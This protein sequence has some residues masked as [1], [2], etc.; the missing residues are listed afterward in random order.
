MKLEWHKPVVDRAGS[1]ARGDELS[2][3]RAGA[4]LSA[5]RRKSDA[6]CGGRRLGR[7]CH[8]ARVLGRV[9]RWPAMIIKVLGSA[10]GGGFP[11][12]NCNCRNC[13]DVRRGVPGLQ[14]RTQSSLAVSGDGRSWALLN[15]SPDLRQQIAATPELWPVHGDAAALQPHQGRR[16]HQRRCRPCRRPAQPARGPRLH[17]LRLGARACG[18]GGQLHLQRAGCAR[19]CSAP[20]C[21]STGRWSCTADCR[22]KRSPCPARSRSI[23]KARRRLTRGR[24]HAGDQADGPR[25][26]RLGLLHPG[27]RRRGCD[28][29]GPAARCRAGPVRRHALH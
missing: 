18:A 10:A 27:L 7:R 28:A 13:A 15:A 25:Q 1:R 14:P 29:G 22:S 19:R 5:R 23:S 2:V 9:R 24:R 12:A 17:A 16:A 6:A 8:Y 3:G 26:R 11:Q 20:S 4:E 21:R